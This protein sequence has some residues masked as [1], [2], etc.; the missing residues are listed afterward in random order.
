MYKDW[1]YFNVATNALIN[2]K[3]Y[4]FKKNK[5]Y[6]WI[7]TDEIPLEI[8][9]AEGPATNGARLSASAEMAKPW[10]PLYTY[11]QDQ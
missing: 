10:F 9:H 11:V 1:I 6:I 5:Y 2:V 7:W 4:I 3:V 8:H